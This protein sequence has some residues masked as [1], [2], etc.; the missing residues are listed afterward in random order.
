MESDKCLISSNLCFFMFMALHMLSLQ[1]M[2]CFLFT[3]NIT[4]FIEFHFFFSHHHHVFDPLPYHL[5]IFPHKIMRILYTNT[6][7]GL[8]FLDKSQSSQLVPIPHHPF[9]FIFFY[10]SHFSTVKFTFSFLKN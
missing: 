9:Y 5:F 8:F 7:D 6:H 1:N 3:T 4:T 2:S 10:F